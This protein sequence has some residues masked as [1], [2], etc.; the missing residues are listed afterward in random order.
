M[1]MS[2][3]TTETVA[4]ETLDKD[5]FYPSMDAALEEIRTLD[6]GRRD[7]SGTVEG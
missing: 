4:L 6:A 7:E 5:H 3:K 1:T 2:G